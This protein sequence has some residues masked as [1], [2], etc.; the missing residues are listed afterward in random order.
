MR[1]GLVLIIVITIIVFL[2]DAITNPCI[3]SI[4]AGT[5]IFTHHLIYVYSLLG[6]LVDDFAFLVLYVT[7]P[8]V[9]VLH[10]KTSPHCFFDTEAANAC[11]EYRQFQH[12]GEQTGLSSSITGTIVTIGVFI[13]AYKLYCILRDRPRGPAPT[14]LTPLKEWIRCRRARYAY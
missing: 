13:A 8:A 1:G 4:Q 9:V 5:I 6:W 2:L 11:G 7:L 3:K 10:W 14:I 12:L